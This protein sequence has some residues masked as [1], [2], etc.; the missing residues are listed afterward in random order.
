LRKQV[1]PFLLFRYFDFFK[2]QIVKVD[3]PTKTMVK[4]MVDETVRKEMVRINE[5]LDKFRKR[6][7]EV[8]ETL[9]NKFVKNNE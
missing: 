9:K 5:L 1:K 2:I 8:E 3:I 6:L 4:E 7:G